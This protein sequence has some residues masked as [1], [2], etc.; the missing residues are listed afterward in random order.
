MKK[1]NVLVM[2]PAYNEAE[3]IRGVIEDYREYA[4]EYDLL[5]INDCSTDATEQILK[6]EKVEYISNPINLGIGG[7]VQA[8]YRYA[9]RNGYEIAVQVDGDGQHDI[10]YVHGM[11]KLIERRKA[12]IVIGSRFIE[13]EGYLSSG[14]RRIGIHFLSGLIWLTTGKRIK[15][16]TSGFRAVNRRFIKIYAEEYPDDYPEPEAI[17]SAV[18]HRGKIA[19][20]PVAMNR[21]KAGESSI[22]LPRSIYYMIKVTL[23]IIVCRISF[24]VRRSKEEKSDI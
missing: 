6:E 21:R 18:M 3:N 23:A 12:E 20:V 16:V 22:T 7:A 4:G 8:G 5:V 1:S 11:I 13:K 9:L 14:V 2:I 19:E 10:R 17:V 15:D 24:G